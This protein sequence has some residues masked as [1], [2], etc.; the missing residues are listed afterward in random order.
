M[1]KR[2]FIAIVILLMALPVAAQYAPEPVNERLDSAPK[3]FRTFFAKFR[4]A[5]EKNRKAEV[6]AMT[7]FPF[8]YGYD[9]G[10]EGTYSRTQFLKN[11]KHV[12]ASFFGE[13]RMEKNPVFSMDTDGSYIISTESAS[14][15]SFARSRNTFKFVAYIV[16]P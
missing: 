3:A 7:R 14:H 1:K 16:E 15:L 5:V 13:Y 9:A 10:D 4:R 8:R 6:A 2:I 12:T 11:F